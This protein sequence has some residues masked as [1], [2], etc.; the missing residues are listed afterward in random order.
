MSSANDEITGEVSSGEP[1]APE[2]VDPISQFL[3]TTEGEYPLV[4]TGE[5]LMRL[6]E[7]RGLDLAAVSAETKIRR[8]YLEAIETMNVKLVPFTYMKM[9]LGAYARHLGL[10]PVEVVRR[11]EIQ[12]GAISEAAEV[13]I[14][15]TPRDRMRAR[16]VSLAG[17]AAAV[18]FVGAIGAIVAT[19]MFGRDGDDVVVADGEIVPVNGA[20][21]AIF[22]EVDLA[23]VDAEASMQLEIHA[24]RRGWLEVRGADGTV[25]RSRTMSEGETFRPRIGA[26]WTVQARDGG[27]FEWRVGDVVISA[28]GPDAT[29]VYAISVDEAAALAASTIEP[30]T[31]AVSDGSPTR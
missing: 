20:R 7:A 22:D 2:V 31:A 16:V 17:V 21:V 6:R 9:Y 14:D 15:T 24:V 8:D 29:P 12:C 30:L 18:V 26:G 10:D 5:G 25:F 4:R 13:E 19:Q 27:A 28:L 1:I 23:R 3:S 11:Y